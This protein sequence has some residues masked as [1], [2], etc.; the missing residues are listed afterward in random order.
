MGYLS[1]QKETLV[2]RALLH[3]RPA[4][5]QLSLTGILLRYLHW[6]QQSIFQIQGHKESLCPVVC[7]VQ[8]TVKHNQG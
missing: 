1:I 5:S 2:S 7:E 3:L 4:A 6:L 8:I